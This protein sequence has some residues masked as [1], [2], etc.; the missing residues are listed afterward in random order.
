MAATGLKSDSL[1][2]KNFFKICLLAFAG[3]IIYGLP[4][5][6]YYYY[7][8]YLAAYGLNNS[9]MGTLGG[10]YGVLGLFSYLIGGIL[11]DKFPAKR[12]LIFSLVATG[13]G[14]VVH[15]IS[16][17]YTTLVAIYGLWGVT[18]LLTFWPA[19]MKI[20]RMQAKDDEQ[21]SAY[22][23]FEG[24]RGAVNAAHMA[25]ATA[26]FGAFQA[27]AAEG[28]G[29]KWIIVF[30]SVAPILCGVLFQ[31]IFKEPRKEEKDAS[32]EPQK[33]FRFGDIL[34][35]LKMPAVWLVCIIT[36]STYTFNLSYFYFTPYATNVL[37]LSAVFAAILT[38]IAQYCRPLGSPIGGFLADRLGK[39]QV[40]LIGFIVM[41][42]GTFV[43]M[44][45]PDVGF[46]SY[47][48][49][50]VCSIF[51][52][53]MYSNFGIYF[54]LLNEG[55]VPLKDA[56]IAIGLVSTIGYLPE[57]LC[58]LLA[59]RTLDAY[60]GATG[61]LIYFKGMIAVAILGAVCSI[62]WMKY[63]APRKDGAK[64]RPA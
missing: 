15:L 46:R 47:L 31:F 38:V 28:L 60:E 27:K 42:V 49:V 3:S 58:P 9:Q 40:M 23:L 26:I 37:G 50:C 17:S 53:A 22:G 59:G 4:Y 32:E 20:V 43:I 1:V 54:S 41:G 13:L 48:L 6:R 45:L 2:K 63:I 52:F 44:N 21:S 10:A 25:I 11:A 19:L 64:A 56:G 62:I 33:K 24:G 30:Y 5:F 14:G 39:A 29:L 34:S 7:D 35:V 16:S 36:A 51:Y 61:Y 57:V 8:A 55:G 12:L 18:S